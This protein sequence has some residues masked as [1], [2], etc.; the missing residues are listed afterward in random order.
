MLVEHGQVQPD[1][2]CP[3][4]RLAHSI[5]GREPLVGRDHPATHGRRVPLACEELELTGVDP[6]S[7]GDDPV[8]GARRP[9][10]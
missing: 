5:L 4:N 2:T 6:P 1:G 9:G 3:R 8:R 7:F 10:T